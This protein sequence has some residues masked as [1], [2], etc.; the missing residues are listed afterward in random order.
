MLIDLKFKN[1]RL[2]A[3]KSAMA[4]MLDYYEHHMIKISKFPLPPAGEGRGE[5]EG[6][7]LASGYNLSNGPPLTAAMRHPVFPDFCKASLSAFI[8]ILMMGCRCATVRDFILSPNGE[9]TKGFIIQRGCGAARINVI[10]S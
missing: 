7:P 3:L 1:E 10:D 6:G 8:E 2:I 5:A 9:R 4:I